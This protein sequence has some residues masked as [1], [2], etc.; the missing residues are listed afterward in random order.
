MFHLRTGRKP[1]VDLVTVCVG[2]VQKR[3]KE[4]EENGKGEGEGTATNGGDLNGS[5][6]YLIVRT[7]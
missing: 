2:G 1:S 3:R 7:S 5:G 6:G 4:K